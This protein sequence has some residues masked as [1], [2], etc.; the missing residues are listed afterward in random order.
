V[1]IGKASWTTPPFTRRTSPVRYGPRALLLCPPHCASLRANRPRLPLPVTMSFCPC[2]LPRRRRVL[3]GCGCVCGGWS[4][5]RVRAL[6]RRTSPVRYG[7]RALLLCP[8][9]CA[10]LRANRPRLPLPVTMSFCH[11][12]LPRRRRVLCG[13]GCVCGGWSVARVRALSPRGC[14]LLHQ[15]AAATCGDRPL[16]RGCGLHRGGRDTVSPPHT[17]FRLRRPP[18]C[19]VLCELTHAHAF[20][21]W[22]PP[23]T[24]SL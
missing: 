11:C 5:T 4:A 8:P 21:C 22:S 7:P 20:D 16:P 14:G 1:T 15:G 24:M 19:V 18:C 6:S 3:C 10:S 9:H 13:C 12:G 23:V 2:G 17:A